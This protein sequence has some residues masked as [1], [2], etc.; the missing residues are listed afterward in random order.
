MEIAKDCG[1]ECKV[2][3]T[4][5]WNSKF[6]LIEH[7]GIYRF[8]FQEGLLYSRFLT[9][10]KYNFF[11]IALLLRHRPQK[12]LY[13]ETLSCIPPVL[14][15]LLF[16]KSE[17]FMHHHEYVSPD[18][19]NSA[20]AYLKFLTFLEN[21]YLEIMNWKSQTNTDRLDLF[22]RDHPNVKASEMSVWPNYPLAAWGNNVRRTIKKSGKKNVVYVGSVSFEN[23]YLPEFLD[24][25]C[26]RPD[27]HFD[28]FSHNITDSDAAMISSYDRVKIRGIINYADLVYLLPHYDV[29]VV[30]YKPV[31]PNVKYCIPNKVVEYLV[32]G[33]FV[34]CPYEIETTLQWASDNHYLSESSLKPDFFFEID[35][36]K[37][38]SKMLTAERVFPYHLFVT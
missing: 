7:S 3:T 22:V 29:G 4:A 37:V 27:I 31:I 35:P 15:K 1:L 9:Y 12:V 21:K 14:Y 18:Q 6:K 36:N 19:I 33:Q 23:S 30:L 38:D 2:I 13:Y 10:L 8:F 24:W 16:P 11:G 34:W 5:S 28:I 25:L 26:T 17:L 32:C 20:S